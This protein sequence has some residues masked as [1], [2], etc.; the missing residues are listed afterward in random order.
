MI[1]SIEAGR[2]LA[3]DAFLTVGHCL[4]ALVMA[5]LGGVAGPLIA[6]RRVRS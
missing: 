4:F 6:G 2:P 5:V 3:E 1:S